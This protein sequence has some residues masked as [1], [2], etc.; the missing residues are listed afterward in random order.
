MRE[1]KA[2]EG[3]K[4]RYCTAAGEGMGEEGRKS[5]QHAARGEGGEREGGEEAAAGHGGEEKGR[6]AAE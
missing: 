4:L 2:G 6:E 5:L 1:L 3:G